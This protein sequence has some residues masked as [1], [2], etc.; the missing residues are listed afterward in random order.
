MAA[1][2]PFT[3]TVAVITCTVTVVNP[4]TVWPGAL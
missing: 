1:I 4:V 3:L 2:S